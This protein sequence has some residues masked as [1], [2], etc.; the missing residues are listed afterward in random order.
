[1]CTL[2]LNA[3]SNSAR[4]STSQDKATTIVLCTELCACFL[5]LCL[6]NGDTFKNVHGKQRQSGKAMGKAMA[7]GR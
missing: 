2:L 1:M 4:I 3:T 7:S 6:L 5:R